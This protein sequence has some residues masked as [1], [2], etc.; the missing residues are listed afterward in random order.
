DWGAVVQDLDLRF[1][2]NALHYFAFWT[3]PPGMSR[4]FSTRFFMARMPAGQQAAPDGSE[5]TR[6][7]WLRPVD[8]LER[9][10]RGDIE[11]MRPTLATLQQLSGY[12]DTAAAFADVDR[13]P[14][15]TRP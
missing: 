13:R 11:L 3:T 1:D 12:V 10:A 2:V 7:E 5:T 8:A 4:R 6:G 14:V 9:H 15:T